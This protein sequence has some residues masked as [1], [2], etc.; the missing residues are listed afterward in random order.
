MRQVSP[1]FR[2]YRAA[3]TESETAEEAAAAAAVA[4]GSLI[5]SVEASGDKSDGDASVYE[6]T[7]AGLLCR[8]VDNSGAENCETPDASKEK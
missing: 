2:R 5:P 6:E 7:E 3:N 1:G 4:G 8:G